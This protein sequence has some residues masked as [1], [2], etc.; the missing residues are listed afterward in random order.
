ML[1]SCCFSISPLMKGLFLSS[2]KN[3][4]GSMSIDILGP[5]GRVLLYHCWDSLGT[6]QEN[7]DEGRSDMSAENSQW[8][9]TLGYLQIGTKRLETHIL[10]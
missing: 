6:Q 5:R 4:W 7:G 9:F 10:F 8:A 2:Q 3:S 1:S